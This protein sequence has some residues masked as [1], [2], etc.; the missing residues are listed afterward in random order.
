MTRIGE[1]CVSARLAGGSG[2]HRMTISGVPQSGMSLSVLPGV[3]GG[4][5]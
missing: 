4:L 3:F 1:A 2:D 5:A